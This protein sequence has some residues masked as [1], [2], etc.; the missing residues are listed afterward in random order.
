LLRAVG[1]GDSKILVVFGRD[2]AAMH[3]AVLHL[4]QGA[5]GVP[6]WIFATTQPLDETAALCAS[7]QVRRGGLG[8]LIEAERRTWPSWVALGVASWN[9]RRGGWW[10]KLAPFLIPPCRALIQ[11]D[12]GDFFPGSPGQVLRHSGRRLRDA[13]ASA[14]HGARDVTHRA[15]ELAGDGLRVLRLLCLIV[16]GT[17]L[18]WTG[19]P[20]CRWFASM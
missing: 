7:V 20:H 6:V 9:G 1:K 8:L 3:R 17:V 10:L 14:W 18:R 16:I 2:A 13:I 5:P 15:F 11:N 4:R 12:S 19:Y